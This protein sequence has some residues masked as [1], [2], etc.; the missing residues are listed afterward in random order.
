M[1]LVDVHCHLTDD[2]YTNLDEV[3]S[4]AKENLEAVVSVVV[5]PKNFEKAFEIQEKYRGFVYL[6]AGIHPIY[7]H[8]ISEE[9]IAQ[10]IEKIRV[11]CD[12]HYHTL[13]YR[14]KCFKIKGVISES[15]KYYHATVHGSIFR[16]R[17]GVVAIGETGLDYYWV[18]DREGREK[19]KVLFEKQIN[20]A[21]ELDLPLVA[22]IRAGKDEADVFG[23]AIGILEKNEAEKV[24]L[25]M[26][27]SKK[28]LNRVLENG[29]SIS[30]NAIAQSSKEHKRIIRTVPLECLMLETDSPYLV[31]EP[32]KSQGVK[33]N[34]PA[35]V[36]RVAERVAEV[37]EVPLEK[38][39]SQTT[40]N[41]KGFFNL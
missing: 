29:W 22:H 17:Y 14:N 8:K 7:V 34:E 9:E 25:H 35:L 24:L 23:D 30:E 20:L 39:I 31:P 40:Q 5:N 21:K 4:R 36:Q 6:A 41:A 2:D 28:N 16:K 12:K 15:G 19:Q 1:K 37:K 11:F 13:E 32:E 3:I 33:I 27:S 38:V 26:F 10:T 18:K